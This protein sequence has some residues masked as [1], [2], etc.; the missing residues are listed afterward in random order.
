MAG[1]KEMKLSS[2]Q[3]EAVNYTESPSLMGMKDFLLENILSFVAVSE[4]VL[5][6]GVC[7][8]YVIT[9]GSYK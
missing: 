6:E 1:W 8:R 7:K 9:N 5:S 3:L 4:V 2:D